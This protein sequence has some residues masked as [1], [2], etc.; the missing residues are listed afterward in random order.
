VFDKTFLWFCRW[1][2]NRTLEKVLAE[3]G[4]REN[5]TEPA[6]NIYQ[7]WFSLKEFGEKLVEPFIIIYSKWFSLIKK[8]TTLKWFSINLCWYARKGPSSQMK[9]NV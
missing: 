8:G 4:F 6:T 3:S 5:L 2:Q 1:V 9:S 7:K